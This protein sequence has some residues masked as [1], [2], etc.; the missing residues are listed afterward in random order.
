M[1]A[2]TYQDGLESKRMK[3]RFLRQED[4]AIWTTFFSDKE[5]VRFFPL[6][7]KPEPKEGAQMWIDKILQRYADKRYG[8]QAMLDKHSDEFIG[9][10]GLL[11]QTVDGILELEVGYSLL[12]EHWGKGYAT[13]AA[14]LFRDYGFQTTNVDSIISIIDPQNFPSQAVAERNGMKREK[15]TVWNDMDIF[16]YRIT[17]EEWMRSR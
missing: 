16:V 2:Y 5:S 10:C 11:V 6:F 14:K 4:L 12:R 8:L 1:E 7:A 17:R 15:Q 9:Q 3:T 13:E